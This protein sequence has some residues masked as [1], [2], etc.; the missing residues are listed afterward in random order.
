MSAHHRAADRN[1]PRVL[2]VDPGSIATGWGLVGGSAARPVLLDAGVI[3]LA[4]R[5]AFA[6]RLHL[7]RSEFEGLLLRL[8]PSEAAVEAP[9]HGTNSR[10]ALQL[11][12]ARGVVLAALG[13]AG[14]PVAEYAPATVKKAVT[15][16]GRAEKLQVQRMIGRLLDLPTPPANTDEADALAVALCHLSGL[17]YRR[18]AVSALAR[19]ASGAGTK[20]VL[21][22]ARGRGRE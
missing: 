9:F 14:V 21:A 8:E 3:R 6:D 1:G 20:R 19:G 10:A 13:G 2:G 18:R 17:E 12:H 22:I 11:A 15:G 7:L 5:A 16:S 4:A